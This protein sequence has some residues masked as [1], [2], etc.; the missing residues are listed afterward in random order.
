MQSPNLKIWE[1]FNKM[2]IGETY[3]HLTTD[4]SPEF[5]DFAKSFLFS[6]ANAI[7]QETL[8]TEVEISVRIEEGSLTIWVTILG[9]LLNALI[10]YGSIRSGIDQLVKDIRNISQFLIEKFFDEISIPEEEIYRL[11]RRLGVPGKIQRLFKKIDRLEKNDRLGTTGESSSV[12]KKMKK[13]IF[14][15]LKEM[16][17]EKDRQFFLQSLPSPI[18]SDLPEELPAPNPHIWVE[19]V[20]AH[21]VAD[22]DLKENG[23]IKKLLPPE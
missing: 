19:E 13:E 10:F 14:Q 23:E 5:R 18:R 1:D 17:E 6:Q 12:M 15:I 3:I 21:R 4:T 7:G 11:E 8:R 16:E 22:H 20:E 2:K 9:T